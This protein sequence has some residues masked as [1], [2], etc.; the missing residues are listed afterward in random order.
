[1]I[2]KGLKGASGYGLSAAPGDN[3]FGAVRELMRCKTMEGGADEM[4]VHLEDDCYK[5]GKFGIEKGAVIVASER[6]EELAAIVEAMPAAT[7]KFWSVVRGVR[8]RARF[9]QAV[10]NGSPTAPTDEQLQS[11]F[12]G[13]YTLDARG[14]ARR[15]Y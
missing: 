2:A 4:R 8:R 15:G 14:G 5:Y 13:S 12:L 7:R 10:C 6:P 1:M 3:A 11:D 9:T